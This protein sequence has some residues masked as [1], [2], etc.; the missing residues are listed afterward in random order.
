MA[1]DFASLIGFLTGKTD[2]SVPKTL[3]LHTNRCPQNHRCPSVS[4]CPT[5]ALKQKG[6]KA[7][8]VDRKKCINCGKCTRY[9]MPG[10]LRMER[11]A[12]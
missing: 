9:C 4:A 11:V 12:Q 2:N 8:T 5:G 1:F 10:V 7:P 3:K 6:F